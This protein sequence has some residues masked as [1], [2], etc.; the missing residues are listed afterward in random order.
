MIAVLPEDI[1]GC[2]WRSGGRVVLWVNGRHPPVRRRFTLAHE[3]GHVRCG[4]NSAIPVDTIQT[5]SGRTTDAREIQANAFAAELLAPAAGVRAVARGEPTLDD[6][7]RIAA[8]Y[9]ISTIAALFRLSTLGLARHSD[10]LKAEIEAGAD[11][12]VFER[13][14]LS[15][16]RDGIAAIGDADL[17][18][19]SPQ[20]EGSA[21]AAIVAGTASAVDAAASAGCEAA[22]MAQAAATI[23]A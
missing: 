21:L 20:L 12:A 19:L 16:V 15:P 6:V 14:E 4:H 17:P 11:V 8:T 22:A 23:G 2:C 10:H 18:R 5:L 3:L 1:A 13:L 9:G 7:A